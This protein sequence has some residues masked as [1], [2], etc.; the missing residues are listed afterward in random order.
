MS[1]QGRLLQIE[2]N[3]T[4]RNYLKKEGKLESKT[5]KKDK[6]EMKETKTPR[7]STQQDRLTTR[8]RS[9]T[10]ACNE[11]NPTIIVTEDNEVSDNQ[12]EQQERPG[13]LKATSLRWASKVDHTT[14]TT[15][16]D[17]TGN[18]QKIPARSRKYGFAATQGTNDLENQVLESQNRSLAYLR[19]PGAHKNQTS[20]RSC[21]DL[22][23][24]SHQYFSKSTKV[25]PKRRASVYEEEPF[26][27]RPENG[28]FRHR[29][30]HSVP[31]ACRFE[32]EF[33]IESVSDQE[34]A[35]LSEILPPVV[36]PSIYAQ[37]S[38]MKQ[39][40]IK[41]GKNRQQKKAIK[42][43]GSLDD[44]EILTKGLMDCRYLRMPTRR[45]SV[46][47]FM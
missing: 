7:V 1:P 36:L 33:D 38:M 9:W 13:T 24:I 2:Y 40:D 23:K 29:S 39:K 6:T 27:L 22:I 44:A 43:A 3:R 17:N 11:S 5:L 18:P 41:S 28:S 30:W 19:P 10:W 47:N 16:T 15:I 42:K 14:V 21:E 8:E 31:S 26:Y 4:P 32:R 37:E 35:S 46:D 12:Q 25:E 45:L 34:A 20:S